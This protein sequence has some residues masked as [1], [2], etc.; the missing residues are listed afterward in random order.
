MATAELYWLIEFQPLM[1]V[2]VQLLPDLIYLA[3]PYFEFQ[4]AALRVEAWGIHGTAS[5][6]QLRV[7]NE[8]AEFLKLLMKWC[9]KLETEMKEVGRDGLKCDLFFYFFGQELNVDY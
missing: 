4:L 1:T 2:E 8:N 3:E 9:V 6:F 7:L 5:V